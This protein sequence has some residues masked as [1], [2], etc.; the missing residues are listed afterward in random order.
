MKPNKLDVLI[1]KSIITSSAVAQ[2]RR[3]QLKVMKA[4]TNHQKSME[5]LT[6]LGDHCL[7]TMIVSNKD[8]TTSSE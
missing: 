7:Q 3:Q 5:L 1:D 4:L 6:N 2:T 8:F